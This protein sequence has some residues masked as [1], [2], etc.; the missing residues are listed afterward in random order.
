[1]ESQC[2][3]CA[4]RVATISSVIASCRGDARSHSPVAHIT[5]PQQIRN[6]VMHPLLRFHEVCSRISLRLSC[7]PGLVNSCSLGDVDVSE[8]AMPHA[9]QT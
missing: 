2:G 7:R 1:M 9:R 6:T 3:Y 4:N 8:T 5:Y